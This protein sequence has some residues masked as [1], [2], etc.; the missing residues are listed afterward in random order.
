MFNI[1]SRNRSGF[2]LVELLIVVAII[3]VLGAILLPVYASAKSSGRRAKC[4]SNLRQIGQAFQLYQ[5]DYSD[6]YPN[7]GDPYL[8]MGRRWRWPLKRYV[9]LAAQK[10]PNDPSNPYKS[11]GQTMSVLKCPEDE[12]PK[13]V[14]DDTSYAYAACFYH[15]PNDV[16]S[17]TIQ[18][19]WDPSSPGPPCVTQSSSGVL[20]PSRKAI[21]TEWLANHSFERNEQGKKFG[22]W[23]YGG[24]RNYLF[25]DGHVQFYN[26]RS[27]L[28]PANSNCPDISRTKR[29]IAGRDI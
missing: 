10:D 25:A 5:A 11:I 28:S 16:D 22:W 21:I 9:I 6:C 2:T 19:L 4:Q 13:S 12:T 26:S 27:I 24:A 29:G 3:A 17:M 7:T 18:Q 1:D 14:W 23:E 8:W 20:Q 15:N